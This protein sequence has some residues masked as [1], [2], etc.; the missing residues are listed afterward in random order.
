MPGEGAPFQGQVSCVPA[1]PPLWV[2]AFLN[3]RLV[4]LGETWGEEMQH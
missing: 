2:R 4:I 3:A 1:K